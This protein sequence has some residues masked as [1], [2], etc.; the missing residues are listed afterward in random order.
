MIA[1]FSASR[2]FIFVGDYG[3]AINSYKAICVRSD[4]TRAA[5]A[6]ELITCAFLRSGFDASRITLHTRRHSPLGA[7]LM[8]GRQ[9][10]LCCKWQ[11]FTVRKKDLRV[12][13]SR[14]HVEMRYPQRPDPPALRELN[15]HIRAGKTHAF[16]G[17]SGSGKSS[18]LALLQRFYDPSRGTITFGGVDHRQPSIDE[19]RASMA[20]VSQDPV[21]FEGTIRWNLSLG[22][23]EP[24][25]VTEE[26]IRVACVQA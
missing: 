23:L 11:K 10:T 20:Y 12:F 6:A 22:A 17:T 13:S 1:A 9:V 26:E 4:C 24:S 15:L 16:C 2:L 8:T 21:L 7:L 18:I 19:L 5:R 3:R 25:S 14:S